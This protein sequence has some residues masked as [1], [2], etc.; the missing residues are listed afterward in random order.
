MNLINK[1]FKKLISILL[2]FIGIIIMLYP[3]LK[4]RYMIYK[5]NQL[6]SIWEESLQVIEENTSEE[7]NNINDGFLEYQSSS[8]NNISDATNQALEEALSEKKLSIEFKNEQK[9]L[10]QEER[11]KREAKIKRR[12]EYIKSHMEGIL[13]IEEIS[14]KLPILK[15]STKNNLNFSI[16][17]IDG[18]GKPWTKGN[19]A[20]AGHR[21]HAFGRNFNRLDE[22]NIGD[23]IKVIDLQNNHYTYKVTQKFIVNAEDIWVLNNKETKKEITLVTCHPLYEKN[24]PTR[25]I[26]KGEM[27]E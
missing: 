13:K 11:R 4:E 17:S 7:D 22:L 3:E 18:T 20:I 26:V 27:I 16:A 5:Q 6:I 21:S 10:Q 15:G 24:P 12:Q 8:S 2:I 1:D 25:L 19:Y 23:Y 14:L 9:R